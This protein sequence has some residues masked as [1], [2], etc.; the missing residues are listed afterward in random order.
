[1]AGV[2]RVAYLTVVST[3]L[4]IPVEFYEII[5]RVTLLRI[6]A[7]VLS[8]VIVGYLITQLKHHALHQRAA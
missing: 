2:L 4:L 5:D 3:S 1:M 7:L 6:G 8:L